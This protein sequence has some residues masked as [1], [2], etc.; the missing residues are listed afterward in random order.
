MKFELQR[1]NERYVT[2]PVFREKR[3]LK[4]YYFIWSIKEQSEIAQ[5]IYQADVQNG[6]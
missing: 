6:E 5:G 4:R 2:A 1:T 3:S